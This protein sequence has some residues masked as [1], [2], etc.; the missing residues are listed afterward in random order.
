MCT[1]VPDS[2]N[3]F[4]NYQFPFFFSFTGHCPFTHSLIFFLYPLFLLSYFLIRDLHQMI[5]SVYKHIKYNH[6]FHLKQ[7]NFLELIS[8][9]ASILMFSHS[10]Q[11]LRIVYLNQSWISKGLIKKKN[12]LYYL[13]FLPSHSFFI[14]L[15]FS[16]IPTT[17]LKLLQKVT[18]DLI[19]KK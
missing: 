11:N 10:N 1:L 13:Q 19:S 17:L 12:C 7:K 9:P 18:I 3:A 5:P 2:Y 4:D 8:S 16:F 14:F 6:S 15:P